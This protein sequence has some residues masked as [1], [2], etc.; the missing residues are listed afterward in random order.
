MLNSR[1][2]FTGQIAVVFSFIVCWSTQSLLAQEVE[3]GTSVI[4]EPVRADVQS[5]DTSLKIP[6]QK[7]TSDS[8]RTIEAAL[9]EQASFEFRQTP[10]FGAIGF[11]SQR[12]EIQFHFDREA[13]AEEGISEEEEVEIDI[14]KITLGDGLDL[15]LGELNLDYIIKNGVLLIT[16]N[17]AADDHY[18]THVYDV[19]ALE[20]D[21]PETLAD[22]LTYTTGAENWRSFGGMGDLSYFRGSFII[23][24]NRRT[25]AEI[26]SVLNRL[27]HDITT[28]AD[29]PDW[30]VRSRSTSLPGGGG[31][32][33]G[34]GAAGVGG[35]GGFF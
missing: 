17:Y 11:L 15:M 12:H 1:S 25:H 13:L 16:T 3:S 30:P 33:F 18:V 29:S 8:E 26:E 23:K 32:G 5:S 27:L 10:L 35:G 20:V 28:N 21:D 2:L 19:R 31:G 4:E 24:Q 22:V 7:F 34:G 14:P 6:V 9:Q